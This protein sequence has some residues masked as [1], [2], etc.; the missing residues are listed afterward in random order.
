[1]G[2]ENSKIISAMD[3]K[4]YQLFTNDSKPYNLNI[5]GIRTVG[6]IPNKFDDWLVIMWKH[7]GVWS[8]H[9]APVTTDP[10]TYWLERDGSSRGMGTAIVKPGQYRGMW[11]LGKHRGKYH[12]LVQKKDVTV[13]RDD[14]KDGLLDLDTAK[15]ETGRFGINQHRSNQNN[16]SINVNKWSA[17]CIVNANPHEFDIQMALYQEAAEVWGDGF[18]FTLLEEADIV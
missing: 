2:M 3:R 7:D 15:E 14:D 12:A 11:G 10:G 5:I 16:E 13:L 4:G 1:M 17:G 18:T 6:R 8:I 9:F